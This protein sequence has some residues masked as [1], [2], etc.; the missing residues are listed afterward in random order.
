MA[1]TRELLASNLHHVFGNRDARSRQEA[2]EETYT[3]DVVFDDP[4]GSVTG[5]AA[6]GAKAA[7]LLDGAPADFV[8]AEDGLVYTG[9]NSGALAWTFGPSGSPVARGV[10]VIT[11]RDGRIASLRTMLS[12]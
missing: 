6:V 9:P 12:E 3:D 7:A 4:E 11:T 2:I 5:R 1:D 8:F 10:D